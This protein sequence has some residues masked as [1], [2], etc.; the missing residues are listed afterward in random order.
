M[1]NISVQ[2]DDM[3]YQQIVGFPMGTNS[4][5]HTADVFSY[6]Y[7]RDFMSIFTNRSF[8]AKNILKVL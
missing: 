3:V 2:F 5:P 8:K 7:E 4:A 1:E 6:C